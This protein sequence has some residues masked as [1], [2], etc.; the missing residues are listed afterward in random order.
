MQI[1]SF[2]V[3]AGGAYSRLAGMV[4]MTTIGSWSVLT[5]WPSVWRMFMGSSPFCVVW[6]RI[7]SVNDNDSAQEIL[8]DVFVH[9]D[10]HSAN[11]HALSLLSSGII[12]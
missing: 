9:E 4:F 2:M 10:V 6:C 7:G 3:L 1:T 11:A 8:D 12:G 5:W